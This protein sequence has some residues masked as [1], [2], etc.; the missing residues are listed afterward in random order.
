MSSQRDDLLQAIY[1]SPE[2]DAPRS[3]FAD[4]LSE[5]GDLL[6]EF[7]H[8]QLARARGKKGTVNRK[9]CVY[10]PTAWADHPTSSSGAYSTGR[11]SEVSHRSS[12]R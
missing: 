11:P 1:D 3:A 6:G 8:L 5:R 10:E 7:I 12:H 2:D 4:Y 9:K